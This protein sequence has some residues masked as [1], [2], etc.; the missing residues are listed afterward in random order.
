MSYIYEG[1]YWTK[2]YLP[3][4]SCPRFLLWLCCFDFL[5]SVLLTII[6]VFVF[7][8]VNIVST[9][10]WFTGYNYYIWY[11]SREKT[12]KQTTTATTKRGWHLFLE[13][14]L[15]IDIP[16]IHTGSNTQKY[17]PVQMNLRNRFDAFWIEDVY[18]TLD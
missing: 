11:G 14:G 17:H 4:R 18:L 12:T 3:Y 10:L 16:I 15:K 1:H 9:V 5:C 7:Y 2:N 6:C 8:S 13:P